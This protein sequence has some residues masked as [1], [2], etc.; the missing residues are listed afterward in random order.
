MFCVHGH[1]RSFYFTNRFNTCNARYIVV[2]E[3]N[4]DKENVQTSNE[5]MWPFSLPAVRYKAF[6]RIAFSH[7]AHNVRI[8]CYV[9]SGVGFKK[10]PTVR[11]GKCD[12]T[13]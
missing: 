4:C 12:K 6:V 3:M 5:V 7:L 2:L 1:M 8:L 13:H 10:Y 11:D 9:S